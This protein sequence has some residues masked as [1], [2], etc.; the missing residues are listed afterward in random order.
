LSIC[1]IAPMG[2]LVAKETR[3]PAILVDNFTWDWIY[4]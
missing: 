4:Q 3:V 2:I 1:E